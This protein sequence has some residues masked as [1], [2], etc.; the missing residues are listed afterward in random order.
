[1][2][3]FH[4]SG[5][6]RASRSAF[7]LIELLVV[8]AIIAVLIGLLLPAVQKVREAAARTQSQNN[9][10][11]MSLAIH[12]CA[13]ANQG[14]LPASAGYFPGTGRVRGGAPAEHGTIMYYLL[15]F[16]EQD[17]VYKNTSDWSWNSGNVIKTFVA[18]GD[19]S[20]P[21][22]Y[23]TWGNRGATSYAANWFAFGSEGTR[24]R[25]PSSWSDGTSQ[26]LTFM[27]RFAL[28]GN[29]GNYAQH[30]WGEDGQGSGPGSQ[31]GNIYSCSSASTS[32]PSFGV[33][34]TQCVDGWRASAFS[35]AG[36]MVSMGDGS[37][38]VVS[39]GVSQGTWNAVQTPAGGEVLG[40]D[41]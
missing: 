14:A 9:L 35:T 30:I 19:S 40:S 26:T 39:A 24:M 22:N 13:D 31:N 17:N 20:M 7:T 15:P 38:R 2:A 41:W 32:L 37:T 5:N 6:G 11:Q 18:P 8:I 3:R 25:F 10:H 23:L 4:L 28:C 12:S 34:Y 36:C 33:T 21:G 1:M 27:E 16:L 29:G